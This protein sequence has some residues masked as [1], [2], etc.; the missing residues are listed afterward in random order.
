MDHLFVAKLVSAGALPS[1]HSHYIRTGFI[2]VCIEFKPSGWH[3]LYPRYH[4]VLVSAALVAYPIVTVY[5]MIDVQEYVA[6]IDSI[7]AETRPH[8]TRTPPE[9]GIS[10]GVSRYR[11]TRT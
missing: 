6:K 5:G 7:R 4:V 11:C 8:P 10:C 1:L 3:L 2:S 9:M